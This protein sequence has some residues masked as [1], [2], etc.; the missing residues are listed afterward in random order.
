MHIWPWVQAVPHAPQLWRSVVMSAQPVG[1]HDGVVAVQAGLQVQVPLVH[2]WPAGQAFPQ[3]PQL[4]TSIATS[5][6]RRPAALEQHLST[7]VQAG[8][9]TAGA[10][11]HAPLT[12]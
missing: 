2:I 10:A 12:Q 8:V 9:Q 11:E 4:C 6:Q 5:A 1:Q 3:A 7:L